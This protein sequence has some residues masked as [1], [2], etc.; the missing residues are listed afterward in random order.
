[1]LRNQTHLFLEVG[2]STVQGCRRARKLMELGNSL[3]FIS[4]VF[5]LLLG[6][7]RSKGKDCSLKKL[8]RTGET[9]QQVQVLALL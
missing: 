4:K 8:G 2:F 7:W 5:I 9:A 3:G 1:M 6:S